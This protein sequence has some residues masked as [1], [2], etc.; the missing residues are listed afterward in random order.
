MHNIYPRKPE[1]IAMSDSLRMKP[2]TWMQVLWRFGAAKNF[3]KH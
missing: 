1:N 2:R 3:V